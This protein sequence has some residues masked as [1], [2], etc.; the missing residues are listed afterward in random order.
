M[1]IKEEKEGIYKF[2]HYAVWGIVVLIALIV[3]FGTFYTI[4]AGV[5]GVLLTFGKPDMAPKTEGLHVKIP[6]IQQIIKMDV[7][8]Q[9]Y[10]VQKAAA[11]SKDLQT[12]TTD[13]TL[14]YYVNP[15]STPEI[16]KSI[17]LNY[18][19]KVIVP[20]VQ[21][22]VK[23]STAEYTAEELITK[24]PEVKEKIDMG[25]RDRLRTWNI[26]VQS[27]SI[28]NFDFSSEFNK[29]IEQKVTAM[30]LKL[31]AEQDLQRIEIEAKQKVVQAQAEA[32]SLRL[33]KQQI[34]SELIQLRQI[35]V[36]SKALDVQKE[37]IQK[38]NG[39][40]PQITGGVTPF[41][42]VGNLQTT[43]PVTTQQ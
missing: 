8:T 34:T 36:Q 32:E 11:A 42:S 17:G 33:Q 5:R 23:A 21:E 24:R 39:V 14:N 18:Q 1:A 6:F 40:L 16:Y 4:P 35:E 12:V 37:A 25:L 15:E 10:E 28:T 31:K 3:I 7:K 13:I 43:Q 19:D 26:V 27:V 29:A 38:W 2:I 41:V 22:V 9:K 30:Q 20:A